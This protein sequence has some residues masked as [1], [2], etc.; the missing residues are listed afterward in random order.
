MKIYRS[1]KLS[2]KSLTAHKLRTFLA[3][4]GIS[5]GVAAVI[6]MVSIG[7]G[8]QREVLQRIEAMGSNLLIVNAGKVKTIVGRKQQMGNVTT[9]KL[10]DSEAILSEC[11]SVAGA[12]PAQDRA[13]KVKYGNV[14]TRATVFG[15]T[16]SFPGIRNFNLARGRFFFEEE[17]RAGLRV[18]VLGGKVQKNLLMGEDPVGETIRVGRIPFRVIGVLE[19]KGVNADGADE[20]NQLFIPIK[21][22]LRRVFNLDYIDTV[23]VQVSERRLTA[24]A[25][26]EIRELLRERHRL[27]RRAKPDDFTIL[28]LETAREAERETTGS[29]TLLITGIAG[30]S[31]LV[32]GIGI[33]AFMLLSIKERTNEIGLRMA[34]GARP[35][36]ILV[37]FLSEALILGLA[38]GLSGMVTGTAGAWLIGWATEWQTVIPVDAVVISVLFSLS[39]GLFFGVYPARKASLLDPI[40]ALR[41]ELKKGV[42]FFNE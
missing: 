10:K 37:Q 20:D 4:V 8:A 2:R 38:G 3:L 42:D 29:F 12:A 13:F 9:L 14:T 23:Y 39:V 16:A 41:A 30:I 26:A 32:G 1:I 34:A 7:K 35:K 31:L 15:T 27:E 40:D 5:I 11:P 19:E 21:S 6:V 18:A 36:D 33:L 28:D 24:K 22:A 17:N 25:A